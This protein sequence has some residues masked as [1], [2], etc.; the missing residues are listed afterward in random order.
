MTSSIIKSVLVLPTSMTSSGKKKGRKLVRAI[1]AGSIYCCML[2]FLDHILYHRAYFVCDV[3]RA[4]AVLTITSKAESSRKVSVQQALTQISLC[5]RL[6]RSE[7]S[8]VTLWLA[9]DLW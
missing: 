9:I 3:L 7:Y 6:A 5:I 2:L 8:L 4:S 1:S